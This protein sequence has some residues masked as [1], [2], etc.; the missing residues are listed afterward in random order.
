ML[1]LALVLALTMLHL[2]FISR[3]NH[4]L[5]QRFYG[6][7]VVLEDER[8]LMMSPGGEMEADDPIKNGTVVRRRG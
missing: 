8:M 6:A 2:P 3:S 1:H 4:G 7:M 5:P